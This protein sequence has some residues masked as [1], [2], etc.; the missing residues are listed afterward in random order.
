MP[1]KNLIHDQVSAIDQ[2]N[3][4]SV[5][6][7]RNP[8]HLSP[9]IFLQ[10]I[11][12][13]QKKSWE[14][15]WLWIDELREGPDHVTRVKSGL[16]RKKDSCYPLKYRF[17]VLTCLSAKRQSSKHGP[18][19]THRNVLSDAFFRVRANAKLPANG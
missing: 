12:A 3:L 1:L 6:L 18:S 5:S 4:A 16:G 8:T 10:Q 11:G 15:G 13:P 14:F 2:L 7:T 9:G 19:Q 17:P